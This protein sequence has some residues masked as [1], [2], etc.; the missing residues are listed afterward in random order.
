MGREE[1]EAVTGGDGAR[2]STVGVTVTT[3]EG[4]G[5]AVLTPLSVGTCLGGCTTP[6]PLCLPLDKL[7]WTGGLMGAGLA[8]GVGGTICPI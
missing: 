1:G 5:L 2:G 7:C 8:A 4:A 6:L 3:G